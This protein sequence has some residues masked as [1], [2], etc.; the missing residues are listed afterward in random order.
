M[1]A[2]TAL[3]KSGI[4]FRNDSYDNRTEYIYTKLNAIKPLMIEEATRN[5]R[6]AAEKFAEDSQSRLGKIKQARQG[7]FSIISRDKN[8]PHIKKVRIV[9]TIEYYLTD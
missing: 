4:T 8:T 5:A 6:A 2:I 1:T 7:Q 3:G 9:S